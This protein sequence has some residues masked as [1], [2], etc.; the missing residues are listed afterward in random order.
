MELAVDEP[1]IAHVEN[2]AIVQK[3]LR[4]FP[5][6]GAV[7]VH[8]FGRGW[9]IIHGIPRGDGHRI[10]QKCRGPELVT[11]CPP[12]EIGWP[13]RACDERENINLDD[14]RGGADGAKWRPK[15]DRAERAH[16]R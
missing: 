12:A 1:V 15:R 16:R 4:E 3:E 14:R 11:G 9:E 10:V 8:R 7:D 13:E 2:C 6:F 5:W